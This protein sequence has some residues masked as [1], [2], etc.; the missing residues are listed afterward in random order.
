MLMI[1]TAFNSSNS[2]R[3]EDLC[4][5]GF[6]RVSV[7]FSPPVRFYVMWVFRYYFVFAP[8]VF[9]MTSGQMTTANSTIRKRASILPQ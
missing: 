9:L 7:I 1:A 6:K 4:V 3:R 8:Q 5:S 2:Y